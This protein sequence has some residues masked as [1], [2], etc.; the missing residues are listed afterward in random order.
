MIRRLGPSDE[1]AVQAFLAQ[2]LQSSF[3]LV[4][5]LTADGFFY[6]GKP[7][8]GIYVGAFDGDTL[9]GVAAHYWNDNLIF[10][11][12]RYAG[13]LAAGALRAS[14][15]PCAG[16]IGPWAQIDA[17]RIALGFSERPTRYNSKE[18]LYGVEL[19]RLQIPEGI[20]SGRVQCRRARPEDLPVLTEFSVA[21]TTENFGDPDMPELRAKLQ[22]GLERD[23]A[24][25]I[26]FVID[27]D[28][29]VVA[30]SSFHGIA[31]GAVQIGGVYTPPEHRGRGYARSVV[32]GSLVMARDA[33]ESKAFLF[34]AETNAAAQRAYEALGF[35]PIGDYGIILFR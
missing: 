9:A 13:E 24:E 18:I 35:R 8:Q 11:A 16:L 15:R 26:L 19:A 30:K 32:A 23:I 14:R 20:V 31:N 6:E 22:S 10:Q 3:I 1:S 12:P 27:V 5:N 7:Y 28:G 17:A 2:R 34:T 21:E 4:A 29:S 25:S 33:G